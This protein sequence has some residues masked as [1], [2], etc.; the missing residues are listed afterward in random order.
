LVEIGGVVFTA[1][2][3]RGR[4]RAGGVFR[5]DDGGLHFV[6][7]SKGLPRIHWTSYRPDTPKSIFDPYAPISALGVSD[8]VL[9]AGTTKLQIFR[10]ED[11]GT[12]FSPTQGL[13]AASND[14]RADRIEEF[15]TV[16]GRTY[17]RTPYKVF[18]SSDRGATWMPAKLWAP[19]GFERPIDSFAAEGGL[20]VA[21]SGGQVI[22]S[23]N[24]GAEFRATA[25]PGTVFGVRVRKGVVYARFQEPDTPVYVSRDRGRTFTPRALVSGV[26]AD[27]LD[28]HV[29]DLKPPRPDPLSVAYRLL[30]T[31]AV[32]ETKGAHLLATSQG[33]ARTHDRGATL[34]PA[35]NG[36]CGDPITRVGVTDSR[37]FVH[38]GGREP[39][40]L[41]VSA[42]A[43]ADFRSQGYRGNEARAFVTRGK[44]LLA[45][46]E[47]GRVHASSDEGDTWKDVE[48]PPSTPPGPVEIVAWRGANRLLV[49]GGILVSR[50]GG[51]HWKDIRAGFPLEPQEQFGTYRYE[52]SCGDVTDR[53]VILCGPTGVLRGSE[54]EDWSTVMLPGGA[55]KVV[56]LASDDGRVYAAT[57]G[58][59]Y[60]SLDDGK[61]FQVVATS[62][63]DGLT[64]SYLGAEQGE[65]VLTAENRAAPS[66]LDGVAV[67]LSRD[68]GT[69]WLRVSNG[70]EF[71]ASS[72]PV[73]KSGVWYVGLESDGVFR[74]GVPSEADAGG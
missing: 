35:G 33:V 22:V 71:P 72:P 49:R 29:F 28:V 68:R 34:D 57:A 44:E 32:L 11:G 38:V 64:L 1:I 4:G 61:S 63:P 56:G 12:S 42:L 40:R 55:A 31:H 5:S 52:L 48:I 15:A 6:R 14:D 19:G 41:L 21:A 65:L 50:D 37:V 24:E 45:G 51:A 26:S 10:S 18:Q 69:T 59:L 27:A 36:L 53:A 17:A 20:L 43:S 70:L 23:E 60:R 74:F 9:L 54:K 3:T 73:R 58:A 16:G 62:L 30:N 8:G 46:D 7:S 67:L 66:V 47:Q 2:N 39:S 25:L 13:P